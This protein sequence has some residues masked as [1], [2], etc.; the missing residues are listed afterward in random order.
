LRAQLEPLAHIEGGWYEFQCVPSFRDGLARMTARSFDVFVVDADLTME[1]PGNVI[2]SIYSI[3]NAAL[4]I[5][6][7]SDERLASGTLEAG[8]DLFIPRSRAVTKLKPMIDDLLDSYINR[9]KRS[10]D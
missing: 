9:Q 8:S 3:N 1:D 7:S 5:T 6:V 4:I 10:S 2:R